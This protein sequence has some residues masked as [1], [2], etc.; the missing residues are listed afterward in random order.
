MGKKG[1]KGEGDGRKKNK[2]GDGPG[3]E[4][5]KL[6]GREEERILTHPYNT[7]DTI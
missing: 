5:R 3:T 7:G 2:E 1:R 6:E 4:W